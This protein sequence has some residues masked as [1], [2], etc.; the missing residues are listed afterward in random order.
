M[1]YLPVIH[2]DHLLFQ[3]VLA[4]LLMIEITLVILR[5]SMGITKDVAAFTF[6][7]QQPY[8]FVAIKASLLVRLHALDGLEGQLFHRF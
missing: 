1:G 2:F 4:S 7:A 3:F 8:L 6:N 5:Q